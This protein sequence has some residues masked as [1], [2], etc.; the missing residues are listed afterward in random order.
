VEIK[1]I[2]KAKRQNFKFE[3]FVKWS[4]AL[5]KSAKA[6]QPVSESLSAMPEGLKRGIKR[7]MWF[8]CQQK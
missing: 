3:I 8:V 6:T 1:R 2:S 7:R 5:T 4:I